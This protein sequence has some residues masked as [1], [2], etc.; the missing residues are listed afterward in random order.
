LNGALQQLPILSALQP[1]PVHM[2]GCKAH[3]ICYIDQAGMKTL[4]D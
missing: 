3:C 2:V 1:Q 4:V